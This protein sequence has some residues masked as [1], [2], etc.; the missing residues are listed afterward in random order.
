LPAPD[1]A[2]H[3]S[4]D[5]VVPVTSPDGL[6]STELYV[7][8]EQAGSGLAA[9]RLEGAGSAPMTPGQA[10]QLAATLQALAF[11]A[12]AGERVSR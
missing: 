4:V 7:A 3:I 10:M 1:G 11:A 9:I 5:Q 6:E 12:V 2:V 8:V